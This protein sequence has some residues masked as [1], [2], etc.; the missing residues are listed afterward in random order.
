MYQFIDFF[1]FIPSITLAQDLCN[2]T[3]NHGIYTS[4]QTINLDV[5]NT[6]S[7]KGLNKN[8]LAENK[9]T[10]PD[11]LVS[12]Y[13]NRITNSLWENLSPNETFYSS[14]YQVSLF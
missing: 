6:L 1:C 4:N 7:N 2:E 9:L 3:V 14:P 11:P 8:T 5:S 12:I 13:R 10:C